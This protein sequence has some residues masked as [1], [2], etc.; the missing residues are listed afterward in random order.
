[1]L[2][3]GNKIVTPAAGEQAVAEVTVDAEGCLVVP[4]LIDNHTHISYGST[5][6]GLQP[7][8]TLL[9]MGITAAVDAGSTGIETCEAFIRSVI[10]QSRMRLFCTLNVSSE[11]QTTR[12]HMEDL[13]PERYDQLALSRFIE[14][15]RTSSRD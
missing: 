3:R 4:G 8:P 13:D 15:T 14:N 1:M 6:L 7:E 9:P 2:I 10:H 5:A 11:G 12:L